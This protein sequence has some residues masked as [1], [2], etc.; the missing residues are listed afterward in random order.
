VIV[1]KKKAPGAYESVELSDRFTSAKFL[2][3]T[4]MGVT[5]VPV[6][7]SGWASQHRAFA[8][9]AAHYR[10]FLVYRI[11]SQTRRPW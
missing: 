4:L 9:K 6:V 11:Y 8:N 10:G 3:A 2:F 1:A 5:V 7:N